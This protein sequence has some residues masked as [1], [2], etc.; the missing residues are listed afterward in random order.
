MNN[1]PVNVFNDKKFI[2][3]KDPGKAH[4]CSSRI[5]TAE[6]LYNKDD[7]ENDYEN[8]K[9]FQ[10]IDRVANGDESP[11]KYKMA[12]K[13]N[14]K[15]WYKNDKNS[16]CEISIRNAN[17]NGRYVDNKV[18]NKTRIHYN[19]NN[20][21]KSESYDTFNNCRAQSIYQTKTENLRNEINPI[22]KNNSWINHTDLSSGHGSENTLFEDNI[23]KCVT[24]CIDQNYVKHENMPQYHKDY[25][26]SNNFEKVEILNN[27]D[28]S[29][30]SE[31]EKCFAQDGK[32]TINNNKN[33]LLNI[34]D[35]INYENKI[36]NKM[37]HQNQERKVQLQINM[38]SLVFITDGD[39]LR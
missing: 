2:N 11:L 21:L 7:H 23:K 13:D 30:Y 16:E 37:A 34:D 17:P 8:I 36:L 27:D 15:P 3:K 18:D 10:N 31:D 32:K 35:D 22:R 39:I 19:N 1:D 25:K 24:T 26:K 5:K 28:K 4:A 14:K 12:Y 6:K 29:S 33:S 20:S 38:K 9:N